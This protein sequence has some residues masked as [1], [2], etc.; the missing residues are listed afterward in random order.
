[1]N[2]F[3]ADDGKFVRAWSHKNQHAIP[4]R[5]LVHAQAHEFHLRSDDRLVNVI[6]AD[7]DPDLA[8]R[9]LFGVTNCRYDVVVVQ[10]R[11]KM[12][13]VHKLPAPSCAAAAKAAAT[14][15]KSTTAAR[16]SPTTPSA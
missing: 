8:G 12:L 16:E 13:W 7:A 11:G 9:L 6:G 10:M 14:A 1:M 2:G 4:F 3:I 15:G 5:Q